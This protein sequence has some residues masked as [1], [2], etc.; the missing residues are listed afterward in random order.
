MGET[1]FQWLESKV[2]PDA[3]FSAHPR[4]ENRKTKAGIPHSLSAFATRSSPKVGY[5]RPLNTFITPLTEFGLFWNTYGHGPKERCRIVRSWREAGEH[6]K[7]RSNVFFNIL[8]FED[9]HV[10]VGDF[11]FAGT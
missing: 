2:Y 7:E 9:F 3:G 5:F 11:C 6:R 8:F 10:P 1:G 4:G